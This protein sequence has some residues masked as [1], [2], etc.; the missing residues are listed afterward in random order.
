MKS[1]YNSLLGFITL[2]FLTITSSLTFAQDYNVT[3]AQ[4]CNT[5]PSAGSAEIISFPNTPASANTDATLTIL[6]SGDLD[7]TGTNLEILDFID[8]D[9]NSLG[10]TSSVTQCTGVGTFTATIPLA[11]LLPWLTDGQVDIT[12]QANSNVAGT[13]CTGAGFCVTGTLS[14]GVTTAPNDIG[15]AS[16]DSPTVFCPGTFDVYATI[17]NFGTNQVS[18]ATVNWSVDGVAQSSVSF[19]GLLDTANGTGSTNAQVLLGSYAFSTNN[20]Y[21]VVAWT[22]GPNG[23]TDTVNVND[24]ASTVKQSSLPPPSNINLQAVQGNQA[25]LAWTGGSANS[26]LWVN[27]TAG[28]PLVG[29]GTPVSS[30]QVTINNLISETDYDFYVREVCPTGDTSLWAGPFSY[31]T[32]FLCPPNSL[33][34]LTGGNEGRTGPSQSQLNTVYSG[35]PLAGNVTSNNGT[36]VWTVPSSGLYKIIAYGAQGGGTATRAGGSGAMAEGEFLLT[37]GTTLNIVVGQTGLI[38]ASTTPAGNR[39]GGGG[40]FVWDPN[41]PAQPLIAAG[42]GGGTNA[43][44]T[45]GALGIDGSD[46]TSGTQTAA[47]VGSPGTAGNGANPGGAGFLTDG[48]NNATSAGTIPPQAAINGAEGGDGFTATSHYGGFGGGGGGGGSPSTTLA[49]GGGGGYS[50]G[51]GQTVPAS[52]GGG[53]GGSFVGGNNAVTMAGV[54]TGAG[55]VIVEILSSGA[56]NDIGV[57]SIDSPGIFCPGTFDVYATI[58]NFGSNQVT[59]A[60]VGWSVDGVSQSPFSFSGLLD[61]VGG[62]GS[63]SAQ[64]NLG[65]FNFNTNNAYDIEVWTSNPNGATDTVSQNDTVS[66]IAQSSLPPPSNLQTT[67]LL[68]NQATLT[69]SGGSSNSWLF[70]YGLTGVPPSGIGTSVSSPTATIF[71][72]SGETTYDFYVREVCPTGD[73]S[74]WAGPLTFT[75]PFFCPPNSYCFTTAGQT[76]NLGPDQN[77]INTA[78]NGTPLS[79]NVI[80]DNGI[81]VWVVPTSGLFHIEAQGAKGGDEAFNN[82]IG[83]KGAKIEGDFVLTQ[84][85]TVRLI[86]G[87]SGDNGSGAGGGGG[88]TFVEI[89]GTLVLAAGAGGGA[90]SDNNGADATTAPSGTNDFPGGTTPGGVNGNGGQ[91]CTSGVN[92]GGA[93]AGYLTDGVSPASGGQGGFAFLNGG[94]GGFTTFGGGFGGGG[95][96]TSITVGGGGGGGYS[97]GAGGQQLNACTPGIGRS[98]GGGGGS[99]NL[100]LNPVGAGGVRDG[101][102][103]LVM[104]VLSSGAT[105][106]IGAVAIDSPT[107]YCPG[108][109]NVVASINNFGINQVT[110]ATVNWEVDGLPQTAVTFNGLLDTAGGSSPTSTQVVLGSFNFSTNNQYTVKVWTS[111]PNNSIDTVGQNDTTSTVVQSSLPPPIN[112]SLVSV[113]GMAATVDW[114]PGSL[115]NS[116]LWT[117]LPV[118]QT[119]SGIGTASTNP[120]ANIMG[121]TPKT[122]YDFYVR[123]V[124]PTGDTSTW[125]GPLNFQTPFFCPPGTFCF[126]NCGQ[127]GHLGPNQTQCNAIYAGSNLAGQVTVSGG[128]QE[129]TIPDGAYEIEVSGAQG[130]GPF[131]GR[132]ARMKGE[133][134]FSGS[135]TIKILVGQKGA[136]PIGSGTNQ[137]GGGGGTFVTDNND[138]PLIIAGGGGG[139]W[140]TSFTPITDA[141]TTTAGNTGGGT[142]STGGAGGT[143]GQGGLTNISADGGG[144]LLGDGT[145]TA[146]GFAFINGG[147][148]GV[149]TASGGE[150]GFGGGGGASSFNNRRAGGGG[151]YSGGG[152][153]HGGTAGIPEGGGGGSF[154]SGNNQANL[155]GANIDDGAVIFRPLSSGVAND[156]GISGVNPSTIVCSGDYDII[157]SAL[158]FGITQVNSFD[159]NWTWNGVPQPSQ[160]ITTLLDTF[161]GAGPS[162][163][164]INLGSQN[165]AGPNTLVVWT[166]NPN[167][168]TDGLSSNDTL[169]I[170]LDPD[171]ISAEITSVTSAEICGAG[172][173]TL[174]A[175]FT[176]NNLIWYDDPALTNQVNSG[177]T[178][179]LNITQTEVFYLR[180]ENTNG[181]NSEVDT[182]I[183]ELNFTPTVNYTSSVNNCTATFT[184][185]VSNN[186]DSVRWDFGNSIGTSNQFNPVYVYPNGS[187]QTFLVTLT[188][189]DGTCSNDT[190]KAVFVNCVTNGL[191]DNL[192]SEAVTIFPNPNK[193]EFTV[194]IE[195]LDIN[196]L[197]IYNLNGVLLQSI[198]GQINSGSQINVSELNSGSYIIKFHHNKGSIIKNL[199][200]I[201]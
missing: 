159:L 157:V 13:L 110:T 36:Q 86:V 1:F 84:G 31:K 29:Q 58:N 79:G 150:G 98:G 161:G 109:Q 168:S 47:N 96:T 28:S 119:P 181:C 92:H 81:Q 134:S 41:S 23:G 185:T 6:Y 11:T 154:N 117:V 3:L 120:I 145:G 142:G 201:D 30:A 164:Q 149:A 72:L 66:S 193:G 56:L 143:A 4:Q 175:T 27:V 42:G 195:G 93:G 121:L 113:S 59:S 101:D 94:N 166:S 48:S 105:N 147:N 196:G 5:G 64:I 171:F 53:G 71:G 90:S 187:V 45:T 99:F 173:V 136:P 162:S 176:G 172:S 188:A 89:N 33:C 37:G 35:T 97:G 17:Q 91:A 57:V 83:G 103:T 61:T 165:I 174:S 124:C 75:T 194:N 15:V 67:V 135:Q 132:G 131:G 190:V 46:L 152:G 88:A 148:G 77:L 179:T 144:G 68:G 192:G 26:W 32:P 167:G 186:T 133:F 80:S 115:S 20:P 87:Q 65:S 18:S 82:N 55:L 156:I 22:T 16:I 180:A 146:G 19:S 141:P 184:S 107:I 52:A 178:Y 199:I 137:F 60:T 182:A 125:A 153:S 85:D 138:N 177:P 191:M 40:S 122:S 106:D 158:N 163:T 118:G 10:Q 63:S 34:F 197:D 73:T 12:A 50:G 74:A 2:L 126:S 198:E 108:P 140:A 104:T 100:G 123:E 62:S 21:N 78:Y 129:W 155:A 95:G 8:E 139:S 151:G 189:Y 38:S 76:G 170:T 14:Y 39:G 130:F 127:D 69:W 44:V 128:I 116:W 51:A 183:A 7:G 9:G 112:L 114:N 102:G 24:T 111:G 49:S 70:A 200:L 43:S 169:T 25:T 160:T 54:R